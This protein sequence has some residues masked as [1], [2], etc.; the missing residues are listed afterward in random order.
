MP[1]KVLV[2]A[3]TKPLVLS[4][5]SHG[6]NYGYRIIKE[7]ERLSGGEL[8]WTD[9]MLYPV[10]KRMEREGLITAQWVQSDAGRKRKYYEITPAGTEQLAQDRSEWLNV[11]QIFARLWSSSEGL[12]LIEE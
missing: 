3:S 6:R 8:Q 9:A 1:A 7:I 10:L 5:L 11:N 2:A 12:D 4:I